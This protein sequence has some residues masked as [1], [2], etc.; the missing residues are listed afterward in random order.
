MTASLPPSYTVRLAAHQNLGAIDTLTTPAG[1]VYV[2]VAIDGYLRST[3][4][5]S[6]EF[7]WFGEYGQL[8]YVATQGSGGGPFSW[9]GLQMLGPGKTWSFAAVTPTDYTACGWAFTGV[10]PYWRP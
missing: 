3:G 7:E 1:A 10:S 8:I 4:S 5:G 6:T 9:R 2:C